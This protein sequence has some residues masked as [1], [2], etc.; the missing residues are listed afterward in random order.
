M[1][2]NIALAEGYLAKFVMLLVMSLFVYSYLW[3]AFANESVKCD[4]KRGTNAD[5][6][7]KLE[8]C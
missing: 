2:V 6:W 3:S 8:F 4:C 7:L 5:F 1:T